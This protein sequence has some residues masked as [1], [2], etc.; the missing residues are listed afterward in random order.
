MQ[1]N[2]KL[3]NTKNSPTVYRIIIISVYFD[4]KNNIIDFSRQFIF[5]FFDKPDTRNSIG[6]IFLP[7][8]IK[9]L[10]TTLISV[11]FLWMQR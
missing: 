1:S 2:G 4:K 7:N 6:L 3:A 5:L 8:T 10:L 9:W 11:L